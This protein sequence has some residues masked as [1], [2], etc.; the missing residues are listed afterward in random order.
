MTWVV[1]AVVG[2]SVV[3]GLIGA[4][5]AQSAADTQAN[6][7]NNAAATQLQMFNTI[8]D[9]N[10][11]Y[12]QAGQTAL[13][14]LTS[15]TSNPSDPN[16]LTHRFNTSDLNANLAPN[17]AFMLTQ[18]QDAINNQNSVSNGLVSGN[19]LKGLEDYTQNTAQSAYQQAFNNY[20]A[21]QT[22]I[23][24]RLSNIAGLGQTANQTTANAGTTAAGNAGSAQMAAG[25]AQAAGTVGSAN[26]L[27]GGLSNVGN[28]Y[29]LNNLTGGGVFGN[30]N[31]ASASSLFG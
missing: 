26:A 21:Q 22:N 13:G 1:T 24:N 16:S 6:A 12:R 10:A 30:G 3:S 31:S 5:A 7:A 18:G 23:F 27:T 25:A 2:G 17:Y 4:H 9:Q 14:R 29:M 28:Y 15:M 19:A 11:P 20:N 8:N